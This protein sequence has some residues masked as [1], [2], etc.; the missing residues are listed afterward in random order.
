MMGSPLSK[1]SIQMLDQG[2]VVAFAVCV[3]LYLALSA[4]N[5]LIS[6]GIFYSGDRF[7]ELKVQVDFEQALS[8]FRCE[9]FVI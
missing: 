9:K 8:L 1:S 3:H 2:A 4:F 7:L 6:A 5:S